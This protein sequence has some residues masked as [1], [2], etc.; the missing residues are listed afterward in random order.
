MPTLNENQQRLFGRFKSEFER[1]GFEVFEASE[2]FALTDPVYPV[3]SLTCRALYVRGHNFCSHLLIGFNIHGRHQL[4]NLSY[5]GD[6]A[7]MADEIIRDFGWAVEQHLNAE[8]AR[9]FSDGND[10]G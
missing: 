2:T 6:P 3:F 4:L 7:E 8:A 9:L 5:A 1:K 10:R